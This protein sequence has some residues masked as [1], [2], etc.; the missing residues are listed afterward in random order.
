MM[1]SDSTKVA[2]SGGVILA[3]SM[4]VLTSAVRGMRPHQSEHPRVAY[5]VAPAPVV[6]VVAPVD[7]ASSKPR[8]LTGEPGPAESRRP[9]PMRALKLVGGMTTLAA[10]GAVGLLVLVRV[11]VEVFK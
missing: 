11:L 2:V 9:A 6:D 4:A 3:T 8:I 1:L 5:D 10:A 7:P